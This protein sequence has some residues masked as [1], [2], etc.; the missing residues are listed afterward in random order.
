MKTIRFRTML[1]CSVFFMLI[2]GTS[3]SMIIDVDKKGL[4]TGRVSDFTSNQPIEF[5]TVDLY[6]ANDSMLVVGTLTDLDGQF[7]I[8]MLDSGN[9]YVEINPHNFGKKLIQSVIINESVPKVNLGEILLFLVPRK[10]SKLFSRAGKSV[11]T[12][13]PQIIFAKKK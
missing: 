6:S 1:I 8:A 3:K 9:Y 12:T 13:E 7:T 4:I 2:A 11:N 10:S 5:V